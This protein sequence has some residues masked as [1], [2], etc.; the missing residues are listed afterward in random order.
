MLS[1]PPVKDLVLIGGGHSHAIALKQLAMNP[2]PGLR[3]TLIADV[4]HTPY[5]GMLPGYIAGLYNFDDCHI[6]LRPLANFAEA[7][8]FVD[9]AIGLDLDANRVRC[10]NRPPVSFDFLSIDIGSTPATLTVPGAEE[11]A[12]AVK[13]I[14]KFLA[15]WDKIVADVVKNPAQKRRFAIV[16]GGAGGVELILAV[17]SHLHRIFRQSG[18]PEDNLE[19]HLFQRGDRL[20]P[21]RHLGVSRR[22]KKVLSRRGIQLHLGETVTKIEGENPHRVECNSG[23][24]VECDRVFWVTQASAA[25]WLKA[26][27]LAVSDRGFILVG[28]TL[29]S[30]SHPHIFAAGDVATMTNHPRPK[31]GVFAVRQGKPLTQNLRRFA[32]GQS[33]KPYRPQKQFLILI[34]TGDEQAIASRGWFRLGP[35]PLIWKWKDRIDREFMDRFDRLS[36]QM[37]TNTKNRPRLSSPPPMRCAG[38]GSKVGGSILENTL[39]KIRAETDFP[40]KDGILIGL[41]R[42]DDAAVLQVTGESVMVQTVDYFRAP[43]DDPFL[44]GKIAANHSLS[45]LFAMGASPHSALAIATLPYAPPEKVEDSLYQLLLGA[46]TVL[47]EAGAVLVG[48][49]TTEG[50]EM[51]FG[52][53]CNGLARP[54]D[55]LRKGGSEP[56][57]VL[58]LTKALG[59]GTLLAADMRLRAKGRWVEGAIA[60]MLR[61][62]GAAVDALRRHG[63]TACTDITGF[64]LLGHLIEMI[65]GSRV[66]VE[67]NLSALPILTGAEETLGQKIYSSLFPENRRWEGAIANREA[68]NSHP[69]YTLLFDPQTSGGLLAAIPEDRADSCLADLRDLGYSDSAIV[70][71]VRPAGATGVSPITIV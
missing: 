54:E 56:G 34:G 4:V 26:S 13:P 5:S 70:G 64:G 55:L 49:H 69:Y 61:S 32:L 30:V 45:D 16:G 57:Q 8:L 11:H 24:S 22:V 62:N 53:M 42:A 7:R 3:L 17:Q 23:F 19:L 15:I 33:L 6:D 21:E 39:K 10:E 14:S 67:L 59:T 25:P 66:S 2:V 71:R 38:C 1:V 68:V 20:L 35:H 12:I 48:G 41:D 51:A 9:R 27:G 52:L 46:V 60:S 18:Q 50:E 65:R 36:P 58:I 40:K 43:F 28:D 44:F 31:A 29:Q 47:N 37:E 63:V